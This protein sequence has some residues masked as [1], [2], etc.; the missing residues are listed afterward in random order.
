[1]LAYVNA[2]HEPVQIIGAQGVREQLTSTGTFV[3][4]LADTLFSVSMSRIRPGEIMLGF[5]DGVLEALSPDGKLYTKN[6]LLSR[7]ER[8]SHSA[9]SLIETIK[10]DLFRHIHDAPQFDDITMIAVHRKMP[11]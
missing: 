3:G 4:G 7:I 11:E 2:G 9:G 10:T 8:Q 1:V 6:R 5:T